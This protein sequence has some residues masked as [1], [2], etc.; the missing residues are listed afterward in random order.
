MDNLVRMPVQNGKKAKKRNIHV[1][2]A[3]DVKRLLNSIINDLRNNE[4]D[5]KSANAIGYL[6]NIMLKAIEVGELE[7]KIQII[8]EKVEDFKGI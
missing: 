1:Q 8:E 5:S 6:A 7:K 4:I 2:D 3:G